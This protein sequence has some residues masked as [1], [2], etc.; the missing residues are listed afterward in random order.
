M[1]LTLCGE[2]Q[3]IIEGPLF[4]FLI[5]PFPIVMLSPVNN[6]EYINRMLSIF[7]APIG[8]RSLHME[9]ALCTNWRA[10]WSHLG[11]VF[12][13]GD[14]LVRVAGCEGFPLWKSVSALND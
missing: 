14:S 5:I 4:L 8:Y 7:G 12:V 13:K 1:K 3:R 6:D 9:C 2:V 10:V 11:S